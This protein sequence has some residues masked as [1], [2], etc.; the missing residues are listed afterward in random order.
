MEGCRRRGRGW[1]AAA[2]AAT[3]VDGLLEGGGRGRAWTRAGGYS[4]DEEEDRR[5]DE[6]DDGEGEGATAQPQQQQQQQQG[7]AQ[8][9]AASTS[10]WGYCSA[11]VAGEAGRQR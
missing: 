10:S 6:E 3:R 2:T 8:D 1:A 4:D 7:R 5:G 11:R 9:R